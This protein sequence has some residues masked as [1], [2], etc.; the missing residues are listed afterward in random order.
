MKIFRSDEEIISEAVKI[1]FDYNCTVTEAV[2]R[3]KEIYGV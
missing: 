3:A 2:E 1:Y